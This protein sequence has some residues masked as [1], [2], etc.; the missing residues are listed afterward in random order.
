[1]SSSFTAQ[2]WNVSDVINPHP[3]FKMFRPGCS[4]GSC[5]DFCF[6][7]FSNQQQSFIL[8]FLI[9]FTFPSSTYPDHSPSRIWIRH[10]EEH[11]SSVF[12]PLLFLSDTVWTWHHSTFSSHVLAD[13]LVQTSRLFFFLYEPL[14]YGSRTSALLIVRLLCESSRSQSPHGTIVLVVCDSQFEPLNQV[15]FMES[16]GVFFL[17]KPILN[18]F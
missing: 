16:K 7:I 10:V 15:C 8:L 5:V 9:S 3:V 13:I 2:L 4:F 11:L 17:F 18:T 14:S 1:M 12:G 6:V